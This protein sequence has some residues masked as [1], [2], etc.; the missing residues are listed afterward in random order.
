MTTELT[1]ATGGAVGK[2]TTPAKATVLVVEDDSAILNLV[3]R[4]LEL[5]GYRVLSTSSSRNGLL[6]W[7]RHKEEVDLLLT[8]VVMPDGINGRE[9]AHR[10]LADKPCLPVIYSSGHNIEL[11]YEEGWSPARIHFVQKPYRPQQLL[12]LIAEILGKPDPTAK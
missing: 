2:A 7:E 10:C 12:H 6:L 9:L 5:H 8:D 4:L 1:P 3:S 11:S